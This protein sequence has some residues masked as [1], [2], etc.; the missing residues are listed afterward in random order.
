MFMCNEHGVCVAMEQN[1]VKRMYFHHKL[2]Y[3]VKWRAICKG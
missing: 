3:T 2:R 1:R